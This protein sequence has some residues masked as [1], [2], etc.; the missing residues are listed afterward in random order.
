MEII[1]WLI[2]ITSP[3]FIIVWLRVKQLD[4]TRVKVLSTIISICMMFIAILLW[5]SYNENEKLK[6]WLDY[7]ANRDREYVQCI[8][9]T[10][11]ENVIWKCVIPFIE[12]LKKTYQ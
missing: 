10:S 2:I 5:T 3:I 11:D 1:L 6:S 12:L 4:K 8:N 7:V 9:T